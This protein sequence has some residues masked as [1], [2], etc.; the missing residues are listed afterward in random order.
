MAQEPP[1][2]RSGYATILSGKS[3]RMRAG[4]AGPVAAATGRH[5]PASP[6][7]RGRNFRADAKLPRW[8]SLAQNSRASAVRVSS[9]T[10]QAGINHSTVS[11]ET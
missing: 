10:R 1:T 3:D 8:F 4:G 9:P 7:R 6:V 11:D 5:T 2:S